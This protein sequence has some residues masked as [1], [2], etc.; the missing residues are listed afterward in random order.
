MLAPKIPENKKVF[1]VRESRFR[2]R[3]YE[4]TSH[5]EK[6]LRVI[7]REPQTFP[8]NAE[9]RLKAAMTGLSL[10]LPVRSDIG[11]GN[12]V[13]S[14]ADMHLYVLLSPSPTGL[15]MELVVYPDGEGGLPFSPGAG[16]ECIARESREEGGAQA[17]VLR[18]LELERQ[19]ADRV[20]EKCLPW[21]KSSDHDYHGHS[22]SPVMACELLM[23]LKEFGEDL[24]LRWPE[25]ESIRVAGE[26]DLSHLALHVDSRGDWLEVSGQVQINER[27]V[28]GIRTLLEAAAT[29]GTRFVPLKE[30]QYLTLSDQLLSRV[31]ELRALGEEN[32][33]RLKV[34]RLAAIRLSQLVEEAQQQAAVV[35][36]T[37]W[38]N[39]LDQHGALSSWVPDLPSGLQAELRDYQRAGFTWL[40]RH[41]RAGAGA[42]LADD[43]GLGK[44]L[45]SLALLL[46]RADQGPALVIAPTSVCG[47][48][49]AEAHRFAPS[50]KVTWLFN[51]QKDRDFSQAG[52][53]DLYIMSYT[54]FQQETLCVAEKEWATVVLDEAQAIKNAGTKRSQAAMRLKAKFRLITTG[55]PI[56]NHL[57]ELWNL[58]RFINP[59]LL[60][61]LDSF[62][63][64]FSIPVE[65]FNDAEARDRLRRLIQ[66]FVLRR[67]KS[68]VLE[69]LP[70]R[71]EVTLTLD[72]SEQERAMYEAVRLEALNNVRGTGDEHPNR[73][74]VLAGIMKLRRACCH[75]SLILP[76]EP[77][78]SSKLNALMEIV[79]ELRESGHRALVFSQ[80]VD[81]LEIIR[82]TLNERGVPCLYLDGATPS[83]ERVRRVKA[84]QEGEG[85]IFLISLKAGGVGLNLTAAD[86]VIHM[87]PWWNPAVEDQASDRAHRFGQTRPVTVYRLISRD[88][89]E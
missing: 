21:L 33:D 1:L 32:S 57:G 2:L 79:D 71:T 75:G 39:L 14:E 3:L 85:E 65:K 24:R 52:P 42:C 84:F 35:S 34:H 49:E 43:M 58:F 12:L 4:V 48:W 45:Q 77:W 89:I 5:Y 16:P 54:L 36:D 38:R 62:T 26:V 87:D 30:G 11:G 88:S 13:T 72:L 73:I 20:F 82:E 69:E 78:N 55:T 25:G 6:L 60:G 29:P 10:R 41:A 68:Q 59:G 64:R 46:H 80:F 47:N 81:Y 9:D 70:P 67:T 50:L 56:E 17:A 8:K 23:T 86:Y 22:Q 27:E 19:K 51:G 74:R 66:P 7:G 15:Q 40:A 76:D 63:E 28:I 31:R 44:T 53:G 18:D 61:S 83:V 37:G